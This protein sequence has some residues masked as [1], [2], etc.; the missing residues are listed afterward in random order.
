MANG[1]SRRRRVADKADGEITMH[2]L[3]TLDEAN[4][5]TRPGIRKTSKTIEAPPC[6]SEYDRLVEQTL[7]VIEASQII[8]L[9]SV[10]KGLDSCLQAATE[11]FDCETHISAPLLFSSKTNTTRNCDA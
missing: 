10:H 8:A 11:V 7:T 2:R 4:D 3:W 5:L 1:H 6:W 9:L